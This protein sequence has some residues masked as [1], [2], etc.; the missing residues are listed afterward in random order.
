M[1][2]K[3][4]KWLCLAMLL[5]SANPARVSTALGSHDGNSETYISATVIARSP[6]PP[7]SGIVKTWVVLTARAHGSQT[8]LLLPY[9]S[10]EQRIP[11]VGDTCTLSIATENANGIA[12]DITINGSFQIIRHGE[13]HSTQVD[14]ANPEAPS[15][16]ER[17]DAHAT[18][19]IPS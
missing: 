6:T 11:E 13:C 9:F 10:D 17:V 7:Y 1:E 14:N 12:G 5:L 18:W 3:L 2:G 19:E 4:M 8:G 15:P 16:G